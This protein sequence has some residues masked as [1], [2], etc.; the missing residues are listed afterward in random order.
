MF[1]IDFVYIL[2]NILLLL[3][4][5]YTGKEIAKGKSYWDNAILCIIAFTLALGLRYG[6]GD[7]Y[8]HYQDFYVYGYDEGQQIVFTWINTIS[9]WMG[10]GSYYCFLVYSFIEIVCAMI[11]LKRYR[12]FAQFLFPMFLIAVIHFN[13]YQIRQALGFSFVF[14]LILAIII[15]SVR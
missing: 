8:F 12:K 11:F 5:Y 2:I 1:N 3:I 10:V 15:Q 4:F 6:R 9:K 14:L 13:E 7:D